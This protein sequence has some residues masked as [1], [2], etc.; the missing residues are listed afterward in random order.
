MARIVQRI[1]RGFDI[2]RRALKIFSQPFKTLIVEPNLAVIEGPEKVENGFGGTFFC[3]MTC[4]MDRINGQF[5]ENVP[6][7]LRAIS[8][9]R[10]AAATT[11]PADVPAYARGVI[12]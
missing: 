4:G 1:E 12:L 2:A 7:L 10:E 9:P 6:D 11:A 3:D 5:D 8:S